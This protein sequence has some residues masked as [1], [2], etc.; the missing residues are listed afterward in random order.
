MSI[1]DKI[2]AE[3]RNYHGVEYSTGRS[4]GGSNLPHAPMKAEAKVLRQLR[5][6]TGLNEE[7]LRKNPKYRRML[8][9]A[10]RKADGSL[11]GKFFQPR[12]EGE[13]KIKRRFLRGFFRQ[14]L[15][16]LQLPLEHPKVLE[17]I[18]LRL[19]KEHLFKLIGGRYPN[20]SDYPLT[21]TLREVRWALNPKKKEF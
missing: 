11:P 10:A 13:T 6:K 3:K 21:T 5:A 9:E 7:E 2:R 14:V 19:S 1:I 17:E 8:S 20:R 16:D 15:R 12:V 18:N 4:P